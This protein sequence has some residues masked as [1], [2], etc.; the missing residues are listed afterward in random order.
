MELGAGF[1]YVGKQVPLQVGERE[2]FLDLLFYH[3]R[4]HCYAVIELKVAEFEPEHAGQLH[5]YIKAVG[6]GTILCGRL[7]PS[8]TWAEEERDDGDNST[9]GILLCK[10]KDKVVAE[11]ALSDIHKPMGVSEYELVRALPD[12]LKSSLPTIEQIEAEF[13]QSGDS[14]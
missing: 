7:K 14:I 13:E 5:F 10:G 3:T 8:A 11:Y 6:I 12:E 2:F 4:L 1:A 9:I